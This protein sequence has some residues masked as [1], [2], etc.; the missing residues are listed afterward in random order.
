MMK[1]F[2]YILWASLALIISSCNEDRCEYVWDGERS[3]ASHPN[4]PK[5][6]SFKNYIGNTQNI[7]PKVL[8]FETPWNGYKFWM[9]YTPYPNGDTDKENPCI[10]VSNDG[11]EWT[12]PTGL[13]NPVVGRPS[14]GYNSDPHIL[15]N[16]KG[17]EM[18]LWWREYRNNN[19]SDAIMRKRS[20]DGVHWSDTE[21]LLP[22]IYD[23]EMRLSP[24]VWIEDDRYILVYSDCSQLRKTEYSSSSDS[25]TWEWSEP[26]T[27]PIPR[28]EL[29]FWHHD[30]IKND[31]GNYK[32]VING[33]GPEC[34]NN[35]SD[36]YYVELSSDFKTATSPIL[37]IPRNPDEKAFDHR[38]IYRSSIVKVGDLY[39][40][41]YS[42]ISK[43]WKR[44][45]ALSV[46]KSPLSLSGSYFK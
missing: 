42:A 23:T 32:L 24:A 12:V 38:C 2:C 13:A 17:D 37:I 3:I 10:A 16:E 29:R 5:P 1:G 25:G 46:G 43:G 41:Y 19:K 30:I 31:D 18:E 26:V 14:E 35:H 45:M 34:S 40:V 36:L 7:H 15:Y 33:Y 4:A 11:I 20:K 44:A 27:L 8:Y 6:L 21:V 22:H 9:T 28:G 39:Y